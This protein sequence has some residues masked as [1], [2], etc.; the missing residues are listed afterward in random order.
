[1]AFAGYLASALT[2]PSG[3][4]LSVTTDA[5]GPTAVTWTA[6][7]YE[8]IIAALAQ[9][10]TDLQAGQAPSGD[11]WD[12]SIS[13]GSGGTGKV[14]I[15]APDDTWSITWSSTA[16][17]DILGFTANISSVTTAQTG[18]DQARGIWLPD[19]PLFVD[20]HWLNAPRVTDHRQTE[21]PTG[22]MITHVGNLK[23]RHRNLR[24]ALVEKQRVHLAAETV[25]NESL[26]RFLMDTQWGQGHAWFSPGAKTIVVA[27]DGN[28]L[29]NT[30][31]AGW[32]LKG[33]AALDEVARRHGESLDIHWDVVFPELVTNS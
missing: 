16:A 7:N 10:E 19:R 8:S 2:I 17:R 30:T 25:T 20:G 27:H 26:E 11:G 18:A 14:T 28:E 24:Y 33:C 6:G 31:V 15:D 5:G 12:L 9:L 29:G 4:S 13:T 23:Y 1:M 32:Y 21:S 3:V 22:F